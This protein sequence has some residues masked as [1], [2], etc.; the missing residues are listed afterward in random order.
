MGIRQIIQ[1]ANCKLRLNSTYSIW[2]ASS[3]SFA[4]AASS[5]FIVSFCSWTRLLLAFFFFFFLFLFLDLKKKIKINSVIFC[6]ILQQLFVWV[7]KY[8]YFLNQNW[9]YLKLK[10]QILIKME[11]E[12]DMTE[13]KTTGI[14]ENS[15]QSAI[16]IFKPSHWITRL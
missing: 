13:M 12:Y 2:T 16:E 14:L 11:K 4:L 15:N 6:L 10:C 9:L 8:F 7:F 3:S 1:M 5:F